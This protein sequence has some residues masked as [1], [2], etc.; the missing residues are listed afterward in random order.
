MILVLEWVIGLVFSIYP[1]YDGFFFSK[2]VYIIVN[3]ITYRNMHIS[4]NVDIHLNY[5]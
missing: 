4:F 3:G 2:E 5:P 1:V